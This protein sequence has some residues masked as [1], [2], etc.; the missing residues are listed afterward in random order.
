LFDADPRKRTAT[1]K[2][3]L[4]HCFIGLNMLSVVGEEY[5]AYSESV[6][7]QY[8]PMVAIHKYDGTVSFREIVKE[9]LL[10][11]KD[12]QVLPG[13]WVFRKSQNTASSWVKRFALIR[14]D[15][16]FFFHSPQNEKPIA[17]VP[18]DGCTVVSPDQGHKTFDEMRTYKANE[19][20]EFDIRHNSRSTVRLYTTAEPER[21]DWM[22]TVRAKAESASI[23]KAIEG[24]TAQNI[25]KNTNSNIIITSTKLTGLSLLP[26]TTSTSNSAAVHAGANGNNNHN[27]NPGNRVNYAAS[28]ASSLPPLPPGDPYAYQRGGAG[29]GAGGYVSSTYSTAGAY[30]NTNTTSG[31]GGGSI[32]QP[33]PSSAGLYGVG[34]GGG[35]GAGAGVSASVYRNNSTASMVSYGSV[36]GAAGLGGGR[37]TVYQGNSQNA[38]YSLN[39]QKT[40]QK[41]VLNKF[42]SR[43]DLGFEFVLLEEN[44]KKKMADQLEARTRENVAR[45]KYELVNVLLCV[46]VGFC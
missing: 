13:G 10:R 22:I 28:D 31:G 37:P 42:R 30:Y 43:K 14:G 12:D 7:G 23:R 32:Y 33:N 18:L 45:A 36:M 4:K 38:P 27:V 24:D 2:I 41:Q 5:I 39:A 6:K 21:A 46:F 1:L 11:I 8:T 20:Y 26:T 29:G 9:D 19:G 34:G 3:D 35:A 25:P 40:V 16:M 17:V 44:L 15:F